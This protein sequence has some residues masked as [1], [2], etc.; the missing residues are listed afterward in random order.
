M[1]TMFKKNQTILEL[2]FQNNCIYMAASSAEEPSTLS[3]SQEKDT[4]LFKASIV[5]NSCF[6]LVA[7]KFLVYLTVAATE[8]GREWD[9]QAE[10]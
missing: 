1:E 9:C 5:R 6:A 3:A 7:G 8:T 4:V 10:D 2:L